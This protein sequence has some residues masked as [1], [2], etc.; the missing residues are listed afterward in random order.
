MTMYEVLLDEKDEPTPQD[1]ADHFFGA[2]IDH[3]S[4]WSHFEGSWDFR[5]S[6]PDDWSMT[7]RIDNPNGPGKLTRIVTH[8]M[9]M[10]AV[11]TILRGDG[12][13]VSDATRQ[14]CRNFMFD[15]GATDFDADT[16]DQVV[17]MAVLGEVVYG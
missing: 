4:W 1:T 12:K 9:L 7:V 2:A 10:G 5:E 3:Y 8:S 14:E 16:A 17:Q 15:R 13:Y 11:R 6:A